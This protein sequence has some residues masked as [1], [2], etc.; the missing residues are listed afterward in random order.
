MQIYPAPRENEFSLIP[1]ELPRLIIAVFATISLILMEV[2]MFSDID[3]MRAM[4][5]GIIGLTV[6]TLAMTWFTNKFKNREER[7]RDFGVASFYAFLTISL[8]IGGV[9]MADALIIQIPNMSFA[10]FAGMFISIL[11]ACAQMAGPHT[12]GESA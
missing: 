1:P 11:V 12:D 5:L 3:T 4:A 8:L 7:V 10:I 9:F 6:I 2:G